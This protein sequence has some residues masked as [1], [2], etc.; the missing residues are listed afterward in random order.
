VGKAGADLPAAERERLLRRI[1]ESPADESDA[2]L[3]YLKGSTDADVVP[4][5]R[6]MLQAVEEFGT[7]IP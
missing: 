2:F 7:C 5:T 6:K 1:L 3:A 4:T